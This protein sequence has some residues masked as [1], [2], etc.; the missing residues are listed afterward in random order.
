VADETTAA[1]LTKLPLNSDIK[2]AKAAFDQ[3]QSVEDKFHRDFDG[4]DFT[5]Q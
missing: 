5:N 4:V 3:A 2:K 1:L